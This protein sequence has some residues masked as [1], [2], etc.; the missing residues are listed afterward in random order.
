MDFT[1]VDTH[2]GRSGTAALASRSPVAPSGGVGVQVLRSPPP[3]SLSAPGTAAPPVVAEVLASA[4]QPLEGGVRA[5]M[6]EGFAHDFSGVRVHTDV[7]ATDSARALGALA[8]TVGRHIVFAADRYEPGKRGG[9]LVL[10]HEL[11]HVVQQQTGSGEVQELTPQVVTADPL[12]REAHAGAVAVSLGGRARISGRMK[13]AAQRQ[14]QPPV[15]KGVIGDLGEQYLAQALDRKGYIVF[16]DWA[17]NV[18]GNGFDLV[19]WDPGSRQVWLMDNKAWTR[20]IDEAPALTGPQFS[21]NLN[22]VKAFLKSNW[23]SREAAVAYRAL[24]SGKYLKVVSNFNAEGARRFTPALFDSG[25][26]VFD[27]RMMRLFSNRAEWLTA[28]RLVPIQRGV[29]LTGARGAATVGTLL[30]VVALIA[31]SVYLY[32]SEGA[33]RITSQIVAE[34]LLGGALIRIAGRSVGSIASLTLSLGTCEPE[35]VVER[36]EQIDMIIAGIPELDYGLLNEKEQQDVRRDIGVLVD[37]PLEVPSPQPPTYP[38]APAPGASRPNPNPP[39]PPP[40][41]ATAAP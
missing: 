10:A 35:S 17:K 26:S 41:H 31:G 11:A 40:P 4:G 24:E 21:T 7:K 29:R 30:I 27:V 18:H 22:Q 2:G 36:R 9:E 20:G 23:S 5:R 19:V 32:R 6:E 34:A 3:S 1:R 13:P 39:P 14:T 38:A 28:F 37:N 16:Q 33:R 25:V 15:D 8:Y 12:E